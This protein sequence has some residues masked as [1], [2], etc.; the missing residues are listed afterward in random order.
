MGLTLGCKA[1]RRTELTSEQKERWL[2]DSTDHAIALA[3]WIRDSVVIDSI[4]RTINTDSLYHLE[5]SMLLTGDRRLPQ[6]AACEEFRLAWRHGG[7][8]ALVAMKRMEDTIW[9]GIEPE[10]VLAMQR[11][12]GP[13]QFVTM[14]R[15]VCG[16]GGW[17]H[18][19]ETLN[20]TP[21]LDHQPRPISPRQPTR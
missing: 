15:H 21:L 7:N 1:Q 2:R 17:P 19:P 10:S 4:A 16:D 14:S 13:G 6:E 20:G 5:H 3:R 12:V 9:R 11:R 8:A 18:A